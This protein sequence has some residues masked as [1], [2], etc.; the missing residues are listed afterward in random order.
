MK[1]VKV[2]CPHCK[3]EDKVK[4]PRKHLNLCVI[5]ICCLEC[6]RIYKIIYAGSHKINVK[7]VKR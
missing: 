5:E 1:N 6:C 4:I 2:I 3:Y 7:D